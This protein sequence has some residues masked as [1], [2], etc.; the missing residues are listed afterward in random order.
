MPDHCK[1]FLINHGKN[2]CPLWSQ[3]SIS[4]F[5]R[6]ILL[7]LFHILAEQV[8]ESNLCDHR[9]SNRQLSYTSINGKMM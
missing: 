5:P 2:P 6:L 7:L 1:S 4:T 8:R 3:C 9:E